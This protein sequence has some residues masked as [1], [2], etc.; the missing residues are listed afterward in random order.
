[1]ELC[2]RNGHFTGFPQLGVRWQRME[3]DAL[4]ASHGMTS[5]QKGVLVRS[6]APLADAARVL[7]PGDV[8]MKFD[9]VQVASDGTVPFRHAPFHPLWTMIQLVE[10]FHTLEL[11]SLGIIQVG[12]YVK[13]NAEDMCSCNQCLL[14][15][16]TQGEQTSLSTPGIQIMVF[17]DCKKAQP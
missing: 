4:K 6:V 14:A 3:S 7:K 16:L 9:G 17:E 5:G 2:R 11:C 13:S 15:P 12:E 8:I 10:S 1:M